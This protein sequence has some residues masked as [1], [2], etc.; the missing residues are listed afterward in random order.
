MKTKLSLLF[1]LTLVAAL[2]LSACE[3]SFSTANIPDA[4]MATDDSGATRTTVYSPDAV[5]YAIIDLANAPDDTTV[6]AAWVAADVEG[7][8]PDL[9]ID[10]TTLT[11]SDGMLIFNL[12]NA[13]DTLWPNGTYRVDIYL[14][15]ELDRSLTF[16]VQ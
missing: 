10:D 3:F 2:V 14:N 4:Y 13:P 6:K 11:S 5:F 1:A 15:D 16:E 8:D 9:A 7:V 12:E